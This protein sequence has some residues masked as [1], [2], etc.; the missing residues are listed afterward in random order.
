MKLKQLLSWRFS[1]IFFHRWLGIAIGV[2]FILWSISGV[3]LMYYGIPHHTAGERLQRLP[4]LD[5]STATVSP[6]EILSKVSGNPF[7]LRISMHDDRPVYRINTGQV[8]GTWTLVYADTGEVMHG[9]SREDTIYTMAKLYPEYT[10]VMRYE[11]YLTGPDMYTHSPALQTHMPLHVLDMRDGNTYYVS[12][13]SG[14]VV[15]HTTHLSRALGFLGYNIHTLYFWR[16]EAWWTPLLHGITWAGLGMTLLG[17]VLGIWR[18]SSKPVHMEHGVASRTPYVG[19]WKWHHYAGLIFGVMMFTWVLSGLISLSVFPAITESFYNADQIQA[20]AR[21]VQGYGA[22][23]DFTPL[24]VDGMRQAVKKIG[25]EFPVKELELQYVNRQPYYVAYRAPDDE[26][27]ANWHSRSAMDFL[28]PTLEWEHRFISATNIMGKP[29]TEF[30]E[31]DLMDMAK[32]A[33]P[34]QRYTDMTWLE[35]PDDYYYHT[36]DSFD[37]GLPRPVRTFPVLR[38]KYDDPQQTW[39]YLTPSHGQLLKSELIDRR[40]RWGYYGLHGLDFAF[41]YNNRPLWDIVVLVLLAGCITM[42]VTV[43]APAYE[44]LKKHYHRLLSL[45]GHGH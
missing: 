8:F 23:V 31:T 36:I 35:Q 27:L 13:K 9:V 12:Q 34:G 18:F 33:M 44:R 43:V 28:T 20:G 38:L 30:H 26:E 3:I 6:Q 11:N 32:T 37:L 24:T 22:A 21:S 14:E 42:S 40:N 17:L 15:M 4:P 10:E 5:L 19:W 1:L 39:L 7:R 29:F 41:L 2:M 45:F 25:E 16:Q